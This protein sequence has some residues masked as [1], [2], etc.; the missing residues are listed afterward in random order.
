MHDLDV[1][2]VHE[3]AH[4]RDV[5][6]APCGPDSGGLWHLS[7]HTAGTVLAPPGVMSWYVKCQQIALLEEKKHINLFVWF[8]LFMRHIHIIFI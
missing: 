3:A 8:L 1:L 4:D 5:G 6:V 2:V 7:P